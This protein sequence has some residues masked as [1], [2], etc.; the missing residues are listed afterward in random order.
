MPLLVKPDY[1][2]NI[3][4]IESQMYLQWEFWLIVINSN[5]YISYDKFV[6]MR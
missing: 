4:H 2:Y 1:V 3:N 5:E 6:L